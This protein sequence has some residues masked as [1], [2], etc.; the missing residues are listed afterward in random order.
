[1]GELEEVCRVLNKPVPRI[2]TLGSV[3]DVVLVKQWM[4]CGDI[5]P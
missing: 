4:G 5:P 1:M 2:P 3:T